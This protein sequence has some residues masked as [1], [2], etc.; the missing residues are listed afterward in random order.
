MGRMEEQQEYSHSGQK[1]KDD[2]CIT[3]RKLSLMAQF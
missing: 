3:A 1:A 2:H